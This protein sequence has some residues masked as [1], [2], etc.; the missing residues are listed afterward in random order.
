MADSL[1]EN[2]SYIKRA[3]V[4]SSIKSRLS[5]S[6]HWRQVAVPLVIFISALIPRILSLGAFMTAD[7]DDQIMFANHFLKSALQGD[8]AGALILGYPGVPTVILGGIG[9]GAR[10]LA[11]YAGLFP[12]PWVQADFFTTLDALTAQGFGVFQYPYDFLVWVRVPMAI[13]A[14]LSIVVVYSLAK[15]LLDER[16]AL[17]A[18]FILAFDPFILAHSRV[19]H[20]DAPLSYFMFLSFLS[21]LVFLDKGAWKWLILS[22]LFGGLAGLSKTPA[23]LLAPILLVS[24]AMYALF[25]PPEVPRSLRWKRLGIALVVWGVIAVAAI[26]ALWPSMW[27]RPVFTIQSI[28]RNMQNI[29]GAHNTTGIFWGEWQ[30]DQNPLYYLIVFPYHLT[31]LTTIGVIAGVVMIGAGLIAY[32]RKID[33]WLTRVLPLAL[34][35]VVYAVIFVAPLSSVAKRGDRYI[36][37]IFFAAGLLTALALW[38]S[39]GLLQQR[40]TSLFNRFQ[41]TAIHLAGGAVLLQILFVL[42]YHPYYLAYFNPLMGGARTAPYR[43]NIGWGEGLDLAA[44]YL[45]K[46]DRP[47]PP[48]VASWYRNQFAPYYKGPTIDLSNQEAALT[49][50]YTVFYLNQVQRGFPSQEILNYFRQREPA[51]VVEIGGIEY[52]WI[53][54]GPII[55]QKPVE[56]FAFPVDSV[57]A[58]AARLYGVDAPVLEMPAD[59]YASADSQLSTGPYLGYEEVNEGL[60]VTLYWETLGSIQDNHGKVN[61]YIHLVDEEGHIWGKVDRLILAGLWRPIRWNPGFYLRDEY[62][63]PIDPATPP[64]TY[65]LEVGLYDFES[66]QNYGVVQNIGRLTLT[67]PQDMLQPAGLKSVELFPAPVND[68]LTLLGH[69][70]VD[71][72]LPPGAEIRGKIFWQAARKLPKDYDIEFSFINKDGD[73]FIISQQSLSPTYPTT[74]WR[75]AEIMGA[76]YSF[77]IPA[78]APP[79]TYPIMVTVVDP[80]SGESVGKSVSPANITV[81]AQE[82]NYELPE[83]VTPVSAVLND[84]I[85]LVGYKLDSDTVE[86]R[87][88]I[89]LTLYWRSLDF[90][91]SNYTV[92]VHAAG[93]DQVIRGQWDSQP[94]RG[95]APTSGW[96]PGEI[97]KD[98]YQIPM[99]KK[100]PA[101]KYDIFVGM[102]DPLTG[103]RLSIY[104][105][106][107]PIS[108]NRVWLGQVQQLEEPPED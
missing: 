33:N 96:I 63:L 3:S 85:E 26:F 13:A 46:L 57:L 47:R 89:G 107:A 62:K 30:S 108:E 58:G 61:V 72:I 45:N 36:L 31:P 54:E 80:D 82:R 20:V 12:L 2:P 10:Y 102:Y 77:R 56:N 95:D 79:D 17:L 55:G 78:F 71:V 48:I 4:K 104:S 75:S 51:H 49:A 84:D 60:P 50:D 90:A 25:S 28:I 106:I 94:V 99:E 39:A 97:I 37:P 40:F 9:A 21:F 43:I 91:D 6:I 53:Y 52:A 98:A 74:H 66:G 22:G 87:G 42:L 81:E 34:G 65:H 38:W 27:T 14:S 83:D 32:I 29:S 44:D 16:L 68:S 35:L 24:G 18:A 69:D 101:W 64:G 105:P 88:A 23:G 15:R 59:T 1:I 76:A 7:E 5:V 92:F 11:H 93:P 8:W 103:E 19:I 70:Y 41:I 86:Y 67:P 73:K 100:A